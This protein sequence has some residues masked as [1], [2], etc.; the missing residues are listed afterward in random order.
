MVTTRQT[1]PTRRQSMKIPSLQGNWYEERSISATSATSVARMGRITASGEVFSSSGAVAI[2]HCAWHKLLVHAAGKFQVFPCLALVRRR[3]QQIS[4]MI[5][6]HQRGV[7]L[8]ETMHLAPQPAERH[9]GG[10]QVLRGDPPDREHD[11]RLQQRDLPY[12]VRQARRHFLGF[13]VA[14]SR[15]PALQYVGDVDVG[16]AIETDGAQHG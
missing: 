5:R 15:G 2:S 14:V 1:Y 10:E 9:G 11:L 7:Q 3:A 12:Q 4:G 8:T 13:G 16:A 6:H